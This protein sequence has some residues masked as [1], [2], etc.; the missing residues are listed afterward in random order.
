MR[1]EMFWRLALKA[2][3]AM[4]HS[5]PFE[6]FF[7]EKTINNSGLPTQNVESLYSLKR[8]I[9]CSTGSI[10]AGESFLTE[11]TRPETGCTLILA[12]G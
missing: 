8:F 12:S 11:L 10:Q 7:F 9:C 4:K 2:A 5:Q 6:T 1:L 3:N